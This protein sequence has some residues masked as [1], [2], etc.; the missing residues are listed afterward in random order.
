M[1]RSYRFV[2]A[3]GTV[4]CSLETGEVLV[5]PVYC[6][7]LKHP[8]A[9]ELVVLLGDPIVARKYTREALR[10]AP[11]RALREFPRAWLL[12]CLAECVAM[13]SLA[14]GRVRALRFMLGIEDAAG[15]PPGDPANDSLV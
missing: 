5:L 14:A 11:W 8:T 1:K 3:V 13:E 2:E 10:K 4:T 7:I 6:G 15:A 12:A 9:E